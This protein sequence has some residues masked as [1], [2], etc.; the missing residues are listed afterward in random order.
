[1]RHTG[2]SQLP[3]GDSLGKKSAENILPTP[4]VLLL[5]LKELSQDF[6]G[7]KNKWKL[8]A[9]GRPPKEQPGKTANQVQESK[10]HAGDWEAVPVGWMQ[11][12]A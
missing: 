7:G 1:M 2:S 10:Q 11:E 8:G 5:S 3:E 12:R 6:L 4:T 9:A